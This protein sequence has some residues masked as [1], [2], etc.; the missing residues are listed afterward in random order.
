[1]KTKKD[2]YT[3]FSE[4]AGH[5]GVDLSHEDCIMNFEIATLISMRALFPGLNIR[6]YL[7]HYTQ[8][9]YRKVCEFGLVNAYKDNHDIRS[10]IRKL[11][12]HALWP[13]TSATICINT[14]VTK[15]LNYLDLF[16]N[17]ESQGRLENLWAE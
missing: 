9:I 10:L 4:F 13:E 16:T 15:L 8:A 12:A 1:M 17:S 11:F 2:Y 5:L 3:V 7:F 6:G 14:Q